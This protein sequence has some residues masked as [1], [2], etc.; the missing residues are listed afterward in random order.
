[1]SGAEDYIA[2][3]RALAAVSGALAAA[4]GL[5]GL[6]GIRQSWLTLRAVR[7]DR[8]GRTVLLL[9]RG[10]LA[11]LSVLTM[12]AAMQVATSAGLIW[13]A[14]RYPDALYPVLA[15]LDGGVTGAYLGYTAQVALGTLGVTAYEAFRALATR[16]ERRRGGAR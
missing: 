1:M 12:V 13:L 2:T 6:W 9:A 3:W 7:A 11:V 4:G 10:D 5:A 14:A 15:A 16:E 8:P